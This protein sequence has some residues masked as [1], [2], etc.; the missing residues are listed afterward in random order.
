MTQPVDIQSQS[1]A[2]FSM[3]SKLTTSS[4]KSGRTLSQISN[5][6]MKPQKCCG[7]CQKGDL[8]KFLAIMVLLF[9]LVQCGIM[10]FLVI[11]FSTRTT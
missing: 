3:A 10:L 7:L 9:D 4:I 11:T 1:A 2:R 8:L 5:E 6:F